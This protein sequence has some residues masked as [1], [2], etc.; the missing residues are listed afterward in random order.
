[1]IR[2]SPC[3]FFFFLFFFYAPLATNDKQQNEARIK[4]KRDAKVK[5][6]I[7]FKIRLSRNEKLYDAIKFTLISPPHFIVLS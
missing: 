3:F 7:I 2:S 1:M 6:I 5:I 4:S